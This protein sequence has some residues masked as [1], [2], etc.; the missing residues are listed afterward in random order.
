M[1]AI[2]QSLP[3]LIDELPDEKAREAIMSAVLPNVLGEH[4]RGRTAV[5]GFDVGILRVA[6]SD[7]EWKC[8]FEQHAGAIVYKLNRALGSSKVRRIEV[9]V[10]QDLVERGRPR[11]ARV[12]VMEA[13]FSP[14]TAVKSSSDAIADL[15][16]RKNFL[17]A[18]AACIERR[19]AI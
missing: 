16:L 1:H 8:E 7:P 11:D 3:G 12:D 18:A 9:I 10:D 19:D 6:V 4:L 15:E 2:F 5:A 14:P 13:T 17:E